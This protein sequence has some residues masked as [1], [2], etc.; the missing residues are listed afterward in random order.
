M[1]PIIYVDPE[2]NVMKA[3]GVAATGDSLLEQKWQYDPCYKQADTKAVQ[4]AP[5]PFVIPR[6]NG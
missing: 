1:E 2:S 5:T 4:S 3:E 6:R